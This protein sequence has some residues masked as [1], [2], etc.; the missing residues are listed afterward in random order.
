MWEYCSPPLKPVKCEKGCMFSEPWFLCCPDQEIAV[1]NY[2]W[3]WGC[4]QRESGARKVEFYLQEGAEQHP[5]WN[6]LLD[7]LWAASNPVVNVCLT[8]LK[9]L[10]IPKMWVC[11]LPS[12]KLLPRMLKGKML[13]LSVFSA[14]G[15]VTC[16]FRCQQRSLIEE[17]G[18]YSFFGK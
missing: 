2:R 3:S 18:L 1:L 16:N 5:G 17:L 7:V 8:L 4:C 10:A 6:A 13:H 15:I 11:L 14:A 9:L 12:R